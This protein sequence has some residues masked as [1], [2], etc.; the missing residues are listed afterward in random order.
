MVTR[1]IGLDEARQ[2]LRDLESGDAIRSVI[3]L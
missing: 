2:A 3:V 1:H